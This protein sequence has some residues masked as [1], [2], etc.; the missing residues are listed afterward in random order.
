MPKQQQWLCKLLAY[1]FNIKYKPGNL[2]GLADALSRVNVASYSTL[3]TNTSPQLALW[4]ALRRDYAAH[5]ETEQLVKAVN[6]EPG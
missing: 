5:S 1:D 6:D 4:E 2:N 3:F